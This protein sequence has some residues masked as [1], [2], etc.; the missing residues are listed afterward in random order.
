MKRLN[1]HIRLKINDITKLNGISQYEIKDAT[2]ISRPTIAKMLEG[3]VSLSID[4][5]EYVLNKQKIDFVEFAKSIDP[6]DDIYSIVSE[7]EVEYTTNP[8]KRIE[9]L[10]REL[11]SKEY[12]IKMLQEEI[13][14]LKNQHN[15]QKE[16]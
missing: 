6:I 2:N 14:K 15:A 7:S 3:K 16:K 10:S 12:Q 11:G 4:I 5:V 1:E 13:S 8:I 9:Q